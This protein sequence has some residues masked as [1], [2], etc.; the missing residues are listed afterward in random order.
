M[1][2]KKYKE[3]YRRLIMFSLTLVILAAITGAFAVVWYNF[4]SMYLAVT[5]F[6][7]GNWLLIAIYAMMLYVFTRIYGGYRIGHLKRG[8]VIYSAFLSMLFV[9]FI[10]YFQISL[11]GLRLVNPLPMV[12]LSIVDVVLI[13]AWATGANALHLRLYPPRQMLLIYGSNSAEQLVYKMVT[14]AEKYDICE[15]VN[16]SVGLVEIYDRIELYNA[17]II[18]D[19]NST[20]R[21]KILKF[22]FDHSIR[23]YIT[24]KISDMI[25]RGADPIHLFDTPLLLCRNQGLTFEQRLFKR[26]TDLLLSGLALV[27]AAPVMLGVAVAIWLHDQGPI[28]YRQKRLTLDGN[29]F[30]IYKF[31][32]MVQNA[33]KEGAQLSPANDSRITPVGRFIRKMRLDEL[34]QLINIF[35]GEM[36][37]VG[38]RPERPEIAEEYEK[39]IPEFSF[40]LKVKAGL[41]GYAQILGKY[42]TIPYDK[43]KLDL[44]YIENYSLLM[45]LKLMLMTLKI[46]FVPEST[47]GIAENAKTAQDVQKM[48]KPE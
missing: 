42:N 38:P 40:R 17:V 37:F 41:T 24:P 26:A 27:I 16:I 30:E 12:S 23:T 48:M 29:V 46:L 34:P 22:C 14:R 18:C 11:L 21:N 4:Y 1:N 45:D 32:S 20:Y 8:D 13:V 2:K 25:I 44:M 43:L 31:R 19:V 10:T 36:S 35:K 6:R 7:K 33:E 15:A 39:V 9:N 5:F 3:Q 28:L 47:E